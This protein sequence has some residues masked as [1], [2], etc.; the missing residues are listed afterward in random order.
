MLVYPGENH[1]ARQKQNQIDYQR[2]I[3]DWFGHFL[4]SEEAAPWI[5]E[6]VSTLTRERWLKEEGKN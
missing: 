6:G 5:S 3:R 1:S 2:R 4:K